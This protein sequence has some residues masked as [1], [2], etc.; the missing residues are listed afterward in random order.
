MWL[1]PVDPGN[2]T[3][4]WRNANLITRWTTFGLAILVGAV[5]ALAL[6]VSV[7]EAPLSRLFPERMI[8]RQALPVLCVAVIAALSSYMMPRLV[9]RTRRSRAVVT[10]GCQGH[11]PRIVA[12]GMGTMKRPP[13]S[14]I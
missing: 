13:Q 10:D 5:G 2:G 12:S 14:R 3:G 1:Y 9:R 7:I 8:G 4:F 6:L 11:H